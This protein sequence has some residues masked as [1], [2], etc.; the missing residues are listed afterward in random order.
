MHQRREHLRNK[1]RLR[2]LPTWMRLN[3]SNNKAHIR[4]DKRL[5]RSK[6]A[7]EELH[8]GFLLLP[9]HLNIYL[10]KRSCTGMGI[11]IRESFVFALNFTDN[12]VIMAQNNYFLE[13]MVS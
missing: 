12:Q 11:P 6:Q 13:F 2:P 10:L 4:I 7:N 3:Y 5:S 9:L 8:Q 1:K